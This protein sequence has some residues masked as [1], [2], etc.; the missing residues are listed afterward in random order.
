MLIF[1]VIAFSFTLQAKDVINEYMNDIYFANGINT[2]RDE[3]QAQLKD[4]IEKQVKKDI[5]HNN[6]SKMNQTVTF[7]LAYNHTLGP[8]LDL[9]EAYEQKK[10]EHK[11]FWWVLNAVYDVYGRIAK[12]GL[13]HI[14]NTM[15]CSVATHT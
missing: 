11:T 7:K 10:A 2:S 1:V 8:A 13:K 12:V 4:L 6:Y 5:F 14:T 3:A 9:L 15:L